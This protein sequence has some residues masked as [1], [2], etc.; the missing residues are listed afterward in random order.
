MIYEYR[1]YYRRKLPHIH[2]PGATL[3]VTFR[4]AGSIPQSVIRLWR[5]EKEWLDQKIE[6]AELQ[7]EFHHKWFKK[8]EDV[9]HQS[10][11]SPKWL[12]DASVAQMVA[13]SLHYRDEKAYQLDAYCIMPNHVHAVFTPL[14]QD[15]SLTPKQTGKGLRFVSD[16]PDL[17]AIMHSL[18]SYTANQANNLLQRSGE[19]WESESYDHWVRDDEEFRRIVKYVLD[20]PVKAGLVNNWRDWQWSYVRDSKF[21]ME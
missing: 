15:E 6:K 10:Q 20:N 8:F 13:D 18:K 9:L 11:E 1:E 21:L 14:L 7:I 16:L 12:S 17:E 2:H 19:F 3:F 4:L 5:A